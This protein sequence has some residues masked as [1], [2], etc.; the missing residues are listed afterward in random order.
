[1]TRS[2][3]FIISLFALIAL[4]SGAFYWFEYRPT[5]IRVHCQ[6][7]Y[8]EIFLE[9]LEINNSKDKDHVNQEQLSA[10]RIIA[11]SKYE[12]CMRRNGIKE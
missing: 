10:Y 2:T 5:K 7:F 12:M 9:L 11:E 6:K 1:M 3:I 4:I 8:D